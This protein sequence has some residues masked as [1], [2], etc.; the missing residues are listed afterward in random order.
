MQYKQR[1]VEPI[2]HQCEFA[3]SELEIKE[4]FS[5]VVLALCDRA[6]RARLR[7]LTPRGDLA[8]VSMSTLCTIV[9]QA[10]AE[11]MNEAA[12]AAFAEF[13][14]MMQVWLVRERQWRM[15]RAAFLLTQLLEASTFSL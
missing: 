7:K 13:V 1:R 6:S 2:V 4:H 10:K 11:D 9:S 8:R 12:R 15:E 5:G 14:L 3:S